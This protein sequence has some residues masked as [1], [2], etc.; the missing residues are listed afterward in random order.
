MKRVLCI[1]LSMII[2]LTCAMAICEDT[3]ELNN[4]AFD[5]KCE[6]LPDDYALQI[7]Q[8]N[9]MTII[10]NILSSQTN[11]PKMELMITFNVDIDGAIELSDVSADNL[12]AIKDS[13]S[14]EYNNL[15]FETKEITTETQ[16]LIAK[17]AGGTDAFVYTVH[18]GNEIEIHLV[19]GE[20]QETLTNDDIDR[21]V[22]ILNNMKF[23]PIEL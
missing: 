7:I 13:Y 20:T 4:T 15:N 23:V 17:A 2:M 3:Q 6:S 1:V 16:L 5:I 11:M 21:V 10:A 22:T 18:E 12:Q 19:P 14:E 9:N 8:Q